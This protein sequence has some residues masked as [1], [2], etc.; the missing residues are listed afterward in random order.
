MLV[1]EQG[2][3]AG[4]LAEIDDLQKGYDEKLAAFE[5]RL[6]QRCRDS[7]DTV[8]MQEVKHLTDALVKDAKK[9]EKEEVG[10]QEKKK[11]LSTKQKKIKKSIQDVRP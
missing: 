1:E 9:F 2:R 11:H 3:N 10:L 5:V 8:D 4:H 7:A 6:V